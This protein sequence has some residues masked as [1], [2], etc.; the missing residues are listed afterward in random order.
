MAALVK[1]DRYYDSGADGAEINDAHCA[2]IHEAGHVM[3]AWEMFGPK[4]VESAA[5]NHDSGCGETL[6]VVRNGAHRRNMAIS[7][8]GF[9]AEHKYLAERPDVTCQRFQGDMVKFAVSARNRG[10]KLYTGAFLGYAEAVKEAYFDRPHFWAKTLEI[11]KSIFEAPGGYL[12]LNHALLQERLHD[13]RIKSMLAA[14]DTPF[15]CLMHS[16]E[17]FWKRQNML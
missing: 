3:M 17:D 7:V 16:N 8:A 11:G 9:V 12:L 5:I 15:Q 6:H 4:S 14:E 13:R 1:P 2:A 10:I